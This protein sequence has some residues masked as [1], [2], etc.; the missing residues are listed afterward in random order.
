MSDITTTNPSIFACAASNGLNTDFD[1]VV[2]A[3]PIQP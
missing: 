2:V 3:C 1:V